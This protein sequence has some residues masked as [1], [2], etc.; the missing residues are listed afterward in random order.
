MAT[1]FKKGSGFGGDD[2]FKIR[3][4]AQVRWSFPVLST[5]TDTWLRGNVLEQAADGTIQLD[6]GAAN[7]RLKML[8]IERRSP[9]GGRPEEDETLGSGFASGLLD[10]GVVV[11][12]QL[13]SGIAVLVND[14]LFTD[15]AGKI[16]N[17]SSGPKLGKALSSAIAGST[18]LTMFYSNQSV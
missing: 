18:A 7:G 8:A 10:E 17:V 1:T 6:S 2:G 12:E 4:G 11:T 9:V 3:Q 15:G 5:L 16:T 14:S 13:S